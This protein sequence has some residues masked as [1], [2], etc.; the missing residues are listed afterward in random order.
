GRYGWPFAYSDERLTRP[1]IRKDG[2]LVEAT[3][4][5]AIQTIAEKFGSIKKNSGADSLAVIGSQRLTNEEAYVFNRFART[6]LGTNN[7]DHAAGLGY[8]SIKNGLAPMLGF[9]ASSNSIRE[10]REARVVL[11][12]GADLT[13]THPVAKNEV[14]LAN[15]RN[16]AKIIVVDSIRTKLVD[17]GGLFLNVPQGA[18]VFVANAMIKFILD[19]GLFDRAALDLRAEGL[20]G[21][22]E[23]LKGYDPATIAG[24]FGLDPELI[25]EAA[26]T[27]AQA[28]SAVIILADGLNRLGDS[29]SL[30]KAAANL[31]VITGHIGKEANGIF[32]LGEKANAQ[33]AFDMG[34]VPDMLPG[35]HSI[36]DDAARSKYSEL[37]GADIPSSQGMCAKDILD[38]A[39]N[40]AI[41]ALYIVA[42]NPV[43]TYPNRQKVSEA[44]DKTEFVV[45]QDMFMSSTAKMAH[46]VLPAAAPYEK[47]GTFTSAD[48]RIQKLSPAT[49]PVCGKTD[50]EIFTL[51][52]AKMGK[53]ELSYKGYADVMLEIASS[54]P[55][56]AGVSYERLG[57]KGLIWPCLDAEDP[58][59]STLYEGGFPIGKAKLAVASPFVNVAS[60]NDSFKLIPCVQKFHSGS[61]SQWSPSL[62]EVCPDDFAEMNR[63]DMDRLGISE[64]S[65]IKISRNGATITLKAKQTRRPVKGTI[66]VP[67]HFSSNKLNSFTDWGSTEILVQVEKA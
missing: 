36:A 47:T 24:A 17:R 30:S 1:L 67:Y 43:D 44:L 31:A 26:R 57:I 27:F 33:G 48:R 13:E 23:S 62:M 22:M 49:K 66:L 18:E 35:H 11:L 53:P 15:G 5:E 38:A 60:S 16:R 34:L 6:V 41:K 12:L 21:L 7:V 45:V 42:E 61:F 55:M 9:P 50:L 2:T 8:Q 52:A 29:V 25:K 20:D 28:E 37:W 64:G 56:Y 14:I 39:S 40:G 19:E 4:D 32:I 3:W 46:V 54:C 65:N 51:L 59:R 10:I 63:S 58:G